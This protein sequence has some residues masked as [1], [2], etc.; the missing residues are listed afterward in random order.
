MELWKK[1]VEFV[2]ENRM[3]VLGGIAGLIVSILLLTIGFFGTLL[4]LLLTVG[5]AI[6]FGSREARVRTA[7]W[8]ANAYAYIVNKIKGRY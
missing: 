8:I 3:Y 2:V 4:I 5:C 6:L 7:Q 1:I